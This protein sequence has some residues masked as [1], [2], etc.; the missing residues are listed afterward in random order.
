MSETSPTPAPSTVGQ[1]SPASAVPVTGPSFE[2]RIRQV[3][4]ILL[5]GLMVVAA[6][7][8]LSA[9]ALADASQEVAVVEDASDALGRVLEGMVD[10]ETGVRGFILT[11]REPFLETYGPGGA[12]ADQALIELDELVTDLPTFD[13]LDGLAVA[14]D[15]WRE[16]ADREIALV[17][18]G[19]ADDA[20]V[21]VESGEPKSRFDAVRA[22]VRAIDLQLRNL[23]DARSGQQSDLER[24]LALLGVAVLLGSL[25]VILATVRWLRRS[26]TEPLAELAGAVGDPD[27][28][29]FASLTGEAAGEVAAVARSADRLRAAKDRERREA[30]LLAEQAERERVAADLHDGPVQSL[31]AVQLRLQELATRHRG[32]VADVLGSG[33]DVLEATQ[34]DLRSLMLDLS[35]PGIGDRPI[36][37]LLASAGPDVLDAATRLE[38]HAPRD[39]VLSLAS[40]LVV[41][42]VAVEALRN[43]AKHADASNVAIRLE[44]QDDVVVVEVVDDGIGFDVT[45][46]PPPGHF[47][48][49][50]MRSLVETLDGSIELTSTAGAG[51]TLR[52]TVPR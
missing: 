49:G 4:W 17:R 52:F 15:A 38:V 30:V 20:V 8:V 24:L 33:I 16:L 5:G 42:R 10:Q 22:F 29:T 39:L 43:V 14:I 2:R 18:D 7:G 44:P 23:R 1:S 25:A 50:I 32:E 3:L 21:I 48:I 26:V 41:H 45:A 11:G 34:R 9:W 37:G 35:P 6:G 13:D 28:R 40:Q 12:S 46:G 36:G 27:E 51:T 47:G 19:R 31:F